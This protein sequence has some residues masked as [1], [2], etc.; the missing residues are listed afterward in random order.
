[1]HPLLI[2]ARCAIWLMFDLPF[3]GTAFMT[4]LMAIPML[5]FILVHM[6]PIWIFLYSI[7]TAKQA[8]LD[9]RYCITNKGIYIQSGGAGK[10]KTQ[11][12]GFDEI[13]PATAAQGKHDLKHRVG[14]VV[15]RYVT[16]IVTYPNGKRH[17]E[18][19]FRIDNTQDY[20]KAVEIINTQK[21]LGYQGAQRKALTERNIPQELSQQLVQPQRREMGS[22]FTVRTD[23]PASPA[24][25][26]SEVM[27]PEQAFFGDMKHGLSSAP[28]SKTFLSEDDAPDAGLLE[29]LPDESVEDL[30]AELFGADAAQQGAFPDP[31]VNPLPPL[32]EDQN[33]QFMQQ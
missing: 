20:A 15:C 29:S 31:T 6:A 7:A 21:G 28:Q 17:V 11:F 3:I 27:D 2:A 22:V 13:Q 8:A 12:V 5:L 25:S 4:G 1:M 18:N 33:G 19:Y 24:A 30:Q 23:I 10:E 14:D 32:P 16:P 9:T 26:F